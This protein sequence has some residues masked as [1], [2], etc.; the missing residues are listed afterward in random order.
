MQNSVQTLALWKDNK[1]FPPSQ[2]FF[3]VVALFFE[4]PLVKLLPYEERL[5][6]LE[7]MK[8]QRPNS[9]C[10]ENVQL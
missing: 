2:A 5:L 7:C 8:P 4:L 9:F 6:L 10:I 1:H 3:R